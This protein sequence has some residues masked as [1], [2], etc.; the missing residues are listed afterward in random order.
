MVVAG[1]LVLPHGRPAVLPGR[2]AAERADLGQGRPGRLRRHRRRRTRRHRAGGLYGPPYNNGTAALQQ[3]GP[4]AW[5]KLAGVTQP[6]DAAHDLRHLPAVQVPPT[7]PALASA[8]RTYTGASPAQQLTW[9]T[10]YDKACSNKVH[11]DN[12][13]RRSRRR[14]GPVPVMMSS[15]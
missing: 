9:A 11:F 5:Q 15:S 14:D 3:V 7:T 2:A 10:A 6:I 1:L 8:L 12:G 13:C 4:V